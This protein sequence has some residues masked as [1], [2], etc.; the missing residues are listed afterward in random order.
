MK[1][2]Y[3]NKNFVDWTNKQNKITNTLYNIN[4]NMFYLNLNYNI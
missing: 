3:R 2:V 4:I 1:R